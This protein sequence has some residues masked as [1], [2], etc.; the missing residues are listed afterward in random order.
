MPARVSASFAQLRM[1]PAPAGSASVPGVRAR[2]SVLPM[3]IAPP[4]RRRGGGAMSIG[5]TENLALTPGTDAE[6]AG[7]GIMRNWAKLALTLA[8]IV[9]L[10]AAWEVSVVAFKVPPY[11]LPSPA[12]V[13]AALWS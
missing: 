5:T 3:L 12:R 7:A 8:G 13:L 10:L 2:F 6:P 9:V 11:I 1:M 4:P